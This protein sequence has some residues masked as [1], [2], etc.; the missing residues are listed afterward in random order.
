MF[1]RHLTIQ[2]AVNDLN[3]AVGFYRDVLG[4]ELLFQADEMGWAELQSPAQ[5]I[6]VGL[7]LESGQPPQTTLMFQVEDIGKAR[8]ELEGQGV[9][10]DGATETIE[11]TASFASF[12]DVSGNRLTLVQDLQLRS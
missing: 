4:L 12:L 6:T 1:T 7:H 11:R 9:T 10:F 5:D 2:L 8:G 3:K